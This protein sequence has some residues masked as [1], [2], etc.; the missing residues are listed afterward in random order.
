[1]AME[2]VILEKMV[3]TEGITEGGRKPATTMAIVAA[4]SAYSIKSCPRWSL[5][6]R[7]SNANIFLLRILLRD[8]SILSH[9]RATN[10]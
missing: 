4:R 1:M 5:Q 2:L 9:V 7:N 8:D 6:K 10:N 3:L